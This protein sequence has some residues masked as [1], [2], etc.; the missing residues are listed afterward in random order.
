MANSFPIMLSLK[1]TIKN[2]SI[3]LSTL[4]N[5]LDILRDGLVWKFHP[6]ALGAN[7][8]MT[9]T[10]VDYSDFKYFIL[11]DTVFFY[12]TASGT[13]A[14]V[15]SDYV[16]FNLPYDISDDIIGQSFATHIVDGG[17]G[18]SGFATKGTNG[19]RVHVHKRDG[20]NWGLGVGRV[21]RVSGFYKRKV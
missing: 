9:F 10:V 6:M 7:G 3:K 18:S 2:W 20:T 15:A 13:T 17:A 21:F 5:L 19:S 11:G 4:S 8:T 16:F 12:A 1:A 14:G